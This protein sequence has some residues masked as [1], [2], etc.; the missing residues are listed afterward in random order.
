M[1]QYRK[2]IGPLHGI[3]ISVKEMIGMKG[4]GLNAGYI[5]YWGDEATDDAHV[6]HILW[7]AGAVFHIRTTQ[8]QSMMQ[9]ETHSNF[10]GTT[11]NPYNRDVS[12]GGSSGGEGALIAMRGSCL[13]VGSDIGGKSD[14][15][16]DL[17]NAK[18]LTSA[19]SIRS[20]AA[21]CGIYGFKPTA[22]RI[23]TDGWKSTQ[24]VQIRSLLS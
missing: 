24:P 12:S 6:L 21:N 4:L 3:P 7:D 22:F 5:A 17:R 1:K 18:C 20:P 13:G 16:E 14:G 9:L 2:P 23:P 11:A 8:L 10:Y 19:G 15:F